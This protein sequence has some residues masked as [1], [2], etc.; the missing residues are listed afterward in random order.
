[1]VTVHHEGQCC[2][3]RS[4]MIRHA[5]TSEAIFNG[6]SCWRRALSTGHLEPLGGPSRVPV[7]MHPSELCPPS[8]AKPVATVSWDP[9]ECWLRAAPC[10]SLT[11]Q[12][13]HEGREGRAVCWGGRG[14]APGRTELLWSHWVMTMQTCQLTRSRDCGVGAF[15]H[16]PDVK[17]APRVL[18]E[19]G[20]L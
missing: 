1:M 6:G 14:R 15:C 3:A 9:G 5:D 2:L 16:S 20:L 11:P 10:P 8:V 18:S 12:R 19:G 17:G 13:K 7:E 4:I